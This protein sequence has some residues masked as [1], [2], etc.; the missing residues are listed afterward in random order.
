MQLSRTVVDL[1]RPIGVLIVAEN[2]SRHL[3]GETI[4]PWYY[5]DG[6]HRAGLRVRAICHARVREDL[7]ADL[8]ADM[9]DRIDFIED[10]R[11][12]ALLSRIGRLFP[13]RIDDL[14]FNQAI[15]ILTQLRMRGAVRRIIAAHGID[16][17]FEPAPIAPRA[18]SAMHGLGVPVVIGPM[19]GGMELPPAFRKLDGA[20]VHRAIQAGRAVADLLHHVMR[21]KLDARVL[22]VG[23][24]RTRRALPKGTKGEIVEVMESGVDIDAIAPKDYKAPRPDEVVSFIFCGRFVDW[25]GIRYL[26]EAFAP[27]ARDGGVRLDLVGDGELFDAISR[28]VEAEGI[29]GSVVLH[30]RVPA[31]A[32]FDL[33]RRAD[34]YVTPSLRE[35]GGMAMME[36]MAVGL[37][38]VSLR[39]GG[40]AQYASDACALFV[41]PRSEAAVVEGLTAAMREL[42]RSPEQRQRLG[43]A[44][45][46][47]I[48]DAELGWD[49]KVRRIAGILEDVAQERRKDQPATAER[50]AQPP[51]PQAAPSQRTVVR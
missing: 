29:A 38:I 9:F 36:A 16:V 4:L 26:V 49:D 1:P 42:A 22:I 17:V 31:A 41:E 10:S 27:L 47:R 35:C 15:H 6:L 7:R 20:I 14:I 25:K 34:V 19:S 51:L 40:G 37:P 13:Y 11:A 45:R 48:F 30:G 32:Y 28:Q 12:Q 3:S 39:W 5:L 33:L 23:N 21:G 24:K 8:P 18:L 44:A 2:I 50:R 43:R 46:Q